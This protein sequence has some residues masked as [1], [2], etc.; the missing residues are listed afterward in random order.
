MVYLICPLEGS[1]I[2]PIS[3]E[4]R[5]ARRVSVGA[6]D[7]GAIMGLSPFANAHDIYLQ[8]VVGTDEEGG[9]EAQNLGNDCEPML[10]IWADEQLGNR[11]PD[12]LME[13]DKKF[14]KL[15]DEPGK[16]LPA[17]ANLDGFSIYEDKR[18]GIEAKTTSMFGAFGETGT[19]EVP[20]HIL[21]QAQWQIFVADLD[22]VVIPVLHGD[23]NLRRTFYSV[24]PNPELIESIK[25]QV[26]DFWNDHV[27][28]KIPPRDL[29]PNLETMTSLRR[30]PETSVDLPEDLVRNWLVTREVKS[31][32]AKDEK[33]AKAALM[34]AMSDAEGGECELG[35][36]TYFKQ[37]R[38]G[39]T[40]QDA[41]F[42]VLRWKGKKK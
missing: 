37:K 27:I 11:N 23:G 25:A 6:S 15:L 18:I 10:V 9:T 28:P 22:R 33:A 34:S 16:I 21:V 40:T 24:D 32:A 1:L 31:Q 12:C 7:V 26:M 38:A 8:K 14:T 42:R 35:T 30:Q 36:L 29:I 17:H 41:E 5:E 19:D 20:D 4:E 39:Y 13:V 3:P 2:L